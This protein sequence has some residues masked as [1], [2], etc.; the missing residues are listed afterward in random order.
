MLIVFLFSRAWISSRAREDDDAET[1]LI[2][3]YQ[4]ARINKIFSDDDLRGGLLEI[5]AIFFFFHKLLLYEM[6]FCKRKICVLLS[7]FLPSFLDRVQSVT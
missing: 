7:F 5:R 1:L 3:D 6:H 4:A 2:R